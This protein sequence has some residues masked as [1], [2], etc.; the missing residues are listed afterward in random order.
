MNLA[1]KTRDYRGYTFYGELYGYTYSGQ[2]I[3]DLT[4]GRKPEDGPGLVCFDIRTPEG[5]W[6]PFADRLWALADC[7][8]DWVPVLGQGKYGDDIDPKRLAEGDSVLAYADANKH[9]MREGCV[10]ESI[11]GPRRK[12]KYVGEG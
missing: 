11:T 8:L 9:Q 12:A 3:Q 5:N 7:N 10:V 6:M 4:Y 1:E 2:K